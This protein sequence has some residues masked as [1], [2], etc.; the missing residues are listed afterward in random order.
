MLEWLKRRLPAALAW[1]VCILAWLILGLVIVGALVLV[2]YF[3]AVVL[4]FGCCCVVGFSLFYFIVLLL[5]G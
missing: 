1:F 4:A 2:V 5:S 3:W